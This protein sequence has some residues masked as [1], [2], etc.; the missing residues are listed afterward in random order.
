MVQV[1][2][3]YYRILHD[4]RPILSSSKI[5]DLM[6]V[7]DYQNNRCRGEMTSKLIL[8]ECK[9]GVKGCRVIRTKEVPSDW[10]VHPMFY[11]LLD[12]GATHIGSFGTLRNWYQQKKALA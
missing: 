9:V 5:G 1:G 7:V 11:E 6:K 10:A 4:K 12:F 3:I 2:D 8:L